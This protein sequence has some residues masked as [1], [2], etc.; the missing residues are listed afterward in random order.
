[1]PVH[2]IP[3]RR[4]CVPTSSSNTGLPSSCAPRALLVLFS[5]LDPHPSVPPIVVN[6][7]GNPAGCS[8]DAG[9]RHRTAACL[10][11]NPDIKLLNTTKTVRMGKDLL[12]FS[13]AVTQWWSLA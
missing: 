1:M 4:V 9:N 8:F 2:A 6:H 3:S 12:R 11:P 13:F 7:T 5:Q 10:P